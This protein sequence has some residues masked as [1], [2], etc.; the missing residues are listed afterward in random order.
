[1][2]FRDCQLNGSYL[3]EFIHLYIYTLVLLN[4]FHIIFELGKNSINC[5]CISFSHEHLL[6]GLEIVQI[7]TVSEVLSFFFFFKILIRIPQISGRLVTGPKGRCERL[8]SASL[9]PW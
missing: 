2:S 1:M 4:W 5:Y 8:L 7:Q 3:Y 6:F 9:F